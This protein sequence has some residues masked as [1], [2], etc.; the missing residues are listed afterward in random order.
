MGI[1]RR[2]WARALHSA[3]AALTAALAAHLAFP[4]Q[5]N[6]IAN[7]GFEAV[8]VA[9]PGADGLVS[10]WK[11]GEPAQ[12]PASWSL[13]AAYPGELTIGTEE[14][15]SGER[16]VRITAPQEGSAHLYQMCEGLE[17]GQWYEVSVWV[18]GGPVIGHFYEYFLDAP[19]GGQPVLSGS[20]QGNEWRRLSGYY[21]PGGDGYLRSALA[22]YPS[23]GRSVEVDDVQILPLERPEVADVGPDITL[24]NSL[25]K[26]SLSGSGVLKEFRCK[27]SDEDY[28]TPDAPFPVLSVLRQGTIVP[29][30]RLTRDGDT[31]DAQFIDPDVK[32]SLRVTSREKHLLFEVLSIEPDDVESLTLEFPIRRL[33][34]IAGAFNATY[35]DE[36][37]ACMF[38]TTVNARNLAA[39]RGAKVRSLRS[40]CTRSH[41]MVGAG[42]ALV[43][44]PR[45]EFNEA[46]MEAER[47]NGLPCPM[48]D[49]QWAR[50]SD[51]AYESYLF[52]TGVTEA[53]IDTLI[54]YAKLGGFG[55][56]IMLKNDF[57]ANHGHFD[58][59]T[60]NFP[61]GVESVKR[62]VWKIHAAGLDAGVH[63]F[64]PSIS[65]NDPYVTPKPD[66]RLAS[67]PC[68][69]LA[70][71]VDDKATTLTLTEQPE[72]TPPNTVRTKAFPGHFLRVGDEV[73]R[74]TD[75]EVGPPFR[76]VGCQRG[77]L[78][79]V[80]AAHPADVEPRHLL[81][82]WGF[83]LVDADS[84]LADELTRNFADLV[85]EC[86]LDMVYFDAS[87]GIQDVYFDRWYYLN[88]MHL[89]YYEKL[90]K[91]V[92]YQ[93]SNGTG[94]DIL[95][96]IV[97]RSA[98]AD[99][100]GDI[101]GY[102]DE[103]WPGI[104]GQAANF[105]RS[106]I[107]WYYMFRDVRPDQIEYVR[108]KAL[109][110]GASISIE[111][112][113][114]SL[115]AL[116]LSRPTFEMLSRYE[117]CRRG[118]VF[119]EATRA[120]L[121][122]PGK[123]FRLFEDGAG[124]WELLR[125]VYEEP[126]TVD[127][128]DGEQNVWTIT[129]D[130]PGPCQLGVEVVRGKREVAYAGYNDP[131]ALTI[132]A[133]DDADAFILSESNA[134]EKYVSGGDKVI[135]E[136]GPAR[137]GVTQS[138]ARSDEAKVG[139]HCLVYSAESDG[140][141]GG[142]SGIGR[143]FDPPLDLSVYRGIG[144]WIHGDAQEE[145]LRVQLR[146]VAGGHADYVPTINF[147][148]W[149]L[150]T[151]ALP[152]EGFDAS[153]VEY[154]LLY[155]NDIPTRAS[156]QVRFDDLRALT[157]LAAESTLQ[158]PVLG[159]NGRRVA[160]PVELQPGQALTSEGPGGVTFW[161][162]GMAPGREL[163]V[164]TGALQLRPGENTIEFSC[165]SPEGFPGDVALL[166][167]RMWPMEE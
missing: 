39:S 156:V 121:Q 25:L 82:M 17:A 89:D 50:F 159:V 56:I 125:A 99:G 126:R 57:L 164:E 161:P 138:F 66:D 67:V 37:G 3:I 6:L 153:Q 158:D 111:C 62:A 15:H 109:G 9:T 77:A 132:E 84:T 122:E 97:P 35:D 64:G 14:A 32:A 117:Q 38:G 74:Y 154:L 22:L 98:S 123:D 76:F 86:D 114:A 149:S 100:H 102:L 20:S 134:Y 146:D 145:K 119:P 108:A 7:S 107:G 85:N 96:H 73:I 13:N 30:T 141:Y 152:T 4:Q 136:T 127:V 166:L 142:W 131:G 93:T 148:G 45:D 133:F 157:G 55:T 120:R 59:N 106:D 103:R 81:A 63:V 87:D 36:F 144:L 34:T 51:R 8:G 165:G 129:N 112:S 2:N 60:T 68:P 23:G 27:A 65:P 79:T 21:Q 41:G 150:H 83:F 46:I 80:A 61:D 42:F 10:G 110:I 147:T 95:W 12:V 70:E 124:G 78:G 5:D 135:T 151:F 53:D 94:S 28:A 91:D 88:T 49:G 44:A 115:E 163:D 155:F 143:R 40:E 29:V 69:P 43:G 31:L 118:N 11:V 24:E 72:L 1:T 47:A 137:R 101:K 105:T 54:E 52:G 75:V 16:F 92:L 90:E 33:D 18:R 104:L 160:F 167:Y 116:P 128:L 139:D 140:Q 71:A 113:R 162:G 19:I 58:I 48:L 130:L 26:L